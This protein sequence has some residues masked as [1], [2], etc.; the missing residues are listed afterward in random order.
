LA[1][2]ARRLIDAT[3]AAIKSGECQR[4]TLNL[5]HWHVELRDRQEEETSRQDLGAELKKRKQEGSR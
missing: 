2:T 1:R 3:A 5:F 4:L